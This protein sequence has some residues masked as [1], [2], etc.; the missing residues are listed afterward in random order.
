MNRKLILCC[1]IGISLISGTIWWNAAQ[2]P[3]LQFVEFRKTEYGRR[4]VFRIVNDSHTS[5][6]FYGEAGIPF[7]R[8]RLPT[9]KGWKVDT[10]GWC[11]TGAYFH[12]V[13]PHSSMEII[14][15]M[16]AEKPGTSY[17]LGVHFEQET[18][19]EAQE[20]MYSRLTRFFQTVRYILHLPTEPEPE[21][22]ALVEVP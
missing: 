6:S 10:L 22:S 7:Y 3:T 2:S 9:T 19:K 13:L 12:D 14:T 8:W 17:A 18:A 20:R 4:A 5:F 11:G 1:L 15:E 21:W 16:P